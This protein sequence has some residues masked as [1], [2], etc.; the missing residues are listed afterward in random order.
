[1]DDGFHTKVGFKNVKA[2]AK[3][4]CCVYSVMAP[5][6]RHTN[7]ILSVNRLYYQ[8][9]GSWFLQIQSLKNAEVIKTS[10]WKFHGKLIGETL[11]QLR[12]HV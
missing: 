3:R 12:R 7:V 9:L 6:R 2:K 10:D 11:R 4:T 5:L 8:G 1:M